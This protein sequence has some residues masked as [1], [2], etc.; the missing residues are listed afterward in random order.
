MAKRAH[1]GIAFQNR[2]RADAGIVA[3]VDLAQQQTASLDPGVF[4]VDGIAH[5]D[6]VADGQQVGRT[7]GH[8]ADDDFLAHFRAERAQP[9]AVQGR[10]AE[11]IGGRRFDQA[12]G[13]P[14][15][16]VSDTP[17]RIAAWLQASCD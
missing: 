10:A 6:V 15:A 1:R 9:P 14:P 4:K 5:A 7:Q 11:Q 12:V 2:V 17:Q 13:Q 3:D 8:R 16:V